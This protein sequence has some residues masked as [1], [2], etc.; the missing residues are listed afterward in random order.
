MWNNCPIC[1]S[2][3][4]IDTWKNVY[5]KSISPG[6]FGSMDHYR[7]DIGYDDSINAEIYALFPLN[8]C[9][10]L[11]EFIIRRCKKKMEIEK[12]HNRDLFNTICLDPG[13]DI[14]RYINSRNK[15]NSLFL[16]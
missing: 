14:S 8:S 16:L 2:K 7:I 4:V 6:Y 12:W 11:Y 5:C 9:S 13:T 3:L 15:L 1:E 10:N